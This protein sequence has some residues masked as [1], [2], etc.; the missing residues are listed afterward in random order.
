MTTRLELHPDAPQPRLVRQV[1][2]VL[3]AGGVIAYPTDTCYA[4]GC[5]MGSTNGVRKIQRIRQM[6][7]EHDLSLICRDLAEVAN[8]ARVANWAYRLLKANTP[9]PYTFILPAKRDVPRRLQNLKRKT[10]GVRVP[11]HHVP[12][13][14]VAEHGEPILSSTLQLPDSDLPMTEAH[15]I[16]ERLAG[17]IDL[18]VDAGICGIEPSTVVDLTGDQARVLRAGKGDPASFE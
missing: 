9:G 11:D 15:E 10:V 5:A 3:R 4:L 17:Q 7:K 13:A 2:D 1:A 12:T 16:Q 18:V 6:S 14:I 8:Y